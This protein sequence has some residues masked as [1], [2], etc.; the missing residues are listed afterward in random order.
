MKPTTG[1]HVSALSEQ[2]VGALPGQSVEALMQGIGQAAR[3]AALVLALAS[4]EQKNRALRAGA[5]AL[6]AQAAEI[7]AAN[8]GDMH[9]AVTRGLSGALVDRLRLDDERVE[10]MA[11]GLED[12]ERLA[13]PIRRGP[14]ESGGAHG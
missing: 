10:A 2:A 4:T 12:I 14:A 13:D 6:R 8:E 5:A 9:Q 7:L 1:S 11:R 3:Q